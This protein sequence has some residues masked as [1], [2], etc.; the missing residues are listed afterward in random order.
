MKKIT[1]I[2]LSILLLMALSLSAAAT[3]IVESDGLADVPVTL[4]VSPA[5]FNVTVP[6]YLPVSVNEY[7]YVSTA[8]N[9][10]II[11]NGH[12]SVKVTNMTVSPATGWLI[13]SYAEVD[14]TLERV[15]AKKIAL[16]ING[17]YTQKNG[18]IS[19]D[20]GNFPVLYGANATASDELVLSYDAVLPAQTET[21]TSVTAAMVVFTIGWNT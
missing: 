20:E 13:V 7:G 1:A 21:L 15:G 9:V 5:R 8:S 19:F 4:T 16:Y 18:S 2:L 11:N 6:T 3:D 14:M 17:E 12:G 10:K